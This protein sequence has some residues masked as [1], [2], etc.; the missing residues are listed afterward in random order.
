MFKG[1]LDAAPFACVLFCLL[2]FLLLALVVPIPGIPIRLPAAL[3]GQT[4]VEGPTIT[5][6]FDVGGPQNPRGTIYFEEQIIGEQ[7]LQRRLAQEVRK[8]PKPPTLVLQVDKNT[9]VEQLNHLEQLA[10]QAGIRDV[11]Q[12]TLPGVFG[13]SAGTKDP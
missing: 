13:A 2:I 11:H 3:P 4:G 9:T 10:V 6:A 8:Y 5:V 12:E 7:E 1:Q